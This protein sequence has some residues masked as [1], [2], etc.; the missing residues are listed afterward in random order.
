[1]LAPEDGIVSNIQKAAQG[2]TYITVGSKTLY[3]SPERTI[4]AK[5]GDKV[6]AGDTLTNGVPNPL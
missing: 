6:Y 2:G 1:M 3:C 4:Q 5:V